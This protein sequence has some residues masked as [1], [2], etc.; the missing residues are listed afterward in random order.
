MKGIGFL[1]ATLGAAILVNGC[2]GSGGGDDSSGPRYFLLVAREGTVGNDYTT[3]KFRLG[4]LDGDD[5]GVAQNHFLNGLDERPAT[6]ELFTYD[7]T[8]GNL[9]TLSKT[10]GS[11][12]LVGVPGTIPQAN[13]GMDFNPT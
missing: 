4:S 5:I 8:S 3:Y 11:L 2:G 9:Y 10:D 1:A 13:Y 7:A 12:S 6:G